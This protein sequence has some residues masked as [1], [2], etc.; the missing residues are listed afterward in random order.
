MVR[1]VEKR[2]A[3]QTLV[4]IVYRMAN[5]QCPENANMSLT[6]HSSTTLKNEIHIS[7]HYYVLIRIQHIMPGPRLAPHK[8]SGRR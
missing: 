5:L 1:P 2:P 4:S 8:G 6:Q 3:L 7:T